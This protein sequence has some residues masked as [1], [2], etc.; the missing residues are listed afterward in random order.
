MFYCIISATM[1]ARG[2]LVK[3]PNC[4]GDGNIRHRSYCPRCRGRGSEEKTIPERIGDETVLHREYHQCSRCHGVDSVSTWFTECQVC[5]GTGK[6]TAELRSSLRRR[7]LV[8]V[9][10]KLAI[11][12]LLIYVSLCALVYFTRQL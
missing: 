12:L 5:E 3:C 11:F 6:I 4:R 2:S 7:R 1:T 10:V 9:L 8:R